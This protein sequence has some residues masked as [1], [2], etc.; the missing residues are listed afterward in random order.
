MSYLQYRHKKINPQIIFL[1]PVP[2]PYMGPSVATQVIL[3][4]KLKD[5][6]ELIH[7]DTSDHRDLNTLGA[8]DFRNIFLALKHYAILL[9]LIITR[10]PA[11]VY[12]PV[13]QTTVGYLRDSG[14]IL[15][16]KLFGRKVVC[17]LRGGNFRNWYDSASSITRFLV[18]TVHSLV[19]CQIVLG[20]C[21]RSLFKDIVA[22]EKI[23]VVPN[24]ADY[25]M[26]V[27]EKTGKDIKVLFL[28]NFI[29]TKGVRDVLHSVPD[30][31]A[32]HGNV[33]FVFAG[34]WQD[35]AVRDEFESFL[36]AH[37]NLPV[38]LVGPVTGDRKKQLLASADIFVFP[39]YYPPEGHPWVIVE[40]MATGLPVISTDQG[41]IKE[42]VIDGRNGF[43]IEKQSPRQV[44]EKIKFLIE[45]PEL[46][47]QMG[48]ESRRLY[49]ENFTEEKMVERMTRAFGSVC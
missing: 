39:S 23:F 10:W 21:L 27:L 25:R 33:V 9:W 43:I 31:Y 44:A 42:S 36:K 1:G 11:M 38:K 13:S 8:I 15:I 40:A 34:S 14:F 4:S 32:E 6:F 48:K 2:P 49:L 47:I 17:H 26:P 24:G 20:E 5:E 16:S 35:T 18:R 45:N 28:A 7:L 3:N 19:D 46:R 12:I 22:D 41:A 29:K 30:V 37:G